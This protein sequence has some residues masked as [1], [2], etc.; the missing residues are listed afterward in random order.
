MV[1][2]FVEEGAK[3]E[4]SERKLERTEIGSKNN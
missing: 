1:T 3:I 4:D 2:M